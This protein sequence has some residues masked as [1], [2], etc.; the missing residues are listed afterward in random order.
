MGRDKALLVLEGR[1]L[2]DRAI[3]CLD[4][5]SEEVVLA[6]GVR[7][8]YGDRGRRLV[9]DR[10]TGPGGG[11]LFGLAAALEHA[12]LG[13]GGWVCALAV[14]LVRARPEHFRALLA[15][16]AREGADACL[17]AT[18]R[19]PEP[20]FAVYHTRCAPAV[21]A[22]LEAGERRLVGFHAGYGP[23]RAVRLEDGELPREVGVD[24]PARNVNS[25]PEFL[26]EGGSLP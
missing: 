20:L 21:R 4:E 14:D 2:L 11:A 25:P 23:V 15:R 10:A 8:R 16:A 19:G 6:C 3:A 24:E 26:R 7:E 13:G 22:A 18:P 17:L 12:E 9:L 5:V 1:T